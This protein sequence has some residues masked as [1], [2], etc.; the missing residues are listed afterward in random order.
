MLVV[1]SSPSICALVDE[2]AAM[3]SVCH[4]WKWAEALPRATFD[5]NGVSVGE[6]S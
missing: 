4:S 3:A 1:A 5:M 2:A 6:M